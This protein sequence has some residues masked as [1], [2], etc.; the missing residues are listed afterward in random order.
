MQRRVLWRLGTI[1]DALAPIEYI[2][3][4]DAIKKLIA[5]V[6]LVKL[7]IFAAAAAATIVATIAA[8]AKGLISYFS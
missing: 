6:R 5:N 1:A 2:V 3:G 4:L 7:Y 8:I